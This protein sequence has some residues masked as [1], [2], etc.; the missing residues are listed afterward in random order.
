MKKQVLK[1]R[2]RI[3]LML[4]RGECFG[5]SLRNR[6]SDESGM[7]TIEMV[8]LIVVLIALVIIFKSGISRLLGNIMEQIDNSASSVWSGGGRE[9][10]AY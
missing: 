2:D 10:V 8:L 7:G 1:L 3:E 9:I 5:R 6:M 4:I